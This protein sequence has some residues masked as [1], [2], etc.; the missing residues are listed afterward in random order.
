MNKKTER[1]I[2]EV[3]KEIK[4]VEKEVE[5]E[6][7]KDIAKFLFIFV[8]SILIIFLSFL[9]KD[10]LS[11]FKALGLIGIFLINFFSS[12]TIFLPAPG[13][14]TVVAGGALYGTLLVGILA[15]LGS[16]LG[17]MIGFVLGKSGKEIFIKNH[18]PVY[19]LLKKHF[20]KYGG[21]IIFAFAL[22]PNPIF[23]AVGIFAGVFSYNPWRFLAIVLA[24]RIMRNLFLA[25]IGSNF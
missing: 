12:A 18:H 2:Q 8:Y 9:L 17:D 23:D 1:E 11:S 25:Y 3:E 15:G 19:R 10:Q 21:V 16:A 7:E 13:I 24:A 22:I 5:R 14:A 6:V 4:V 20:H